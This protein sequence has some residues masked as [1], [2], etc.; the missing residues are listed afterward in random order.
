MEITILKEFK[1]SNLF[2]NER[3]VV[4]CMLNDIPFTVSYTEDFMY[5]VNSVSK[6]HITET[7]IRPNEPE[8]E[9]TK[10]MEIPAEVT[11]ADIT[12]I[13]LMRASLEEAYK[14]LSN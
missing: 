14:V 7:P 5:T 4:Y 2:L 9:I 1:V 3:H 12:N 13:I 8:V 6:G 10:D 11:V